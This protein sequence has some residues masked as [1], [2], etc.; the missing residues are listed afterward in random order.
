MELDPEA[1]KTLVSNIKHFL[2]LDP[3]DEDEYDEMMRRLLAFSMV[4]DDILLQAGE[5]E[6]LT[7]LEKQS[8][9]INTYYQPV[10]ILPSEG[11]NPNF[12][13]KKG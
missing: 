6:P 8:R 13:G 2:T 1:T 12:S 4:F 9:K 5:R 11:R 10:A 7:D 3:V